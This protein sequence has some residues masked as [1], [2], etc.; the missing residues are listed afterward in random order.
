[1]GKAFIYTLDTS[2]EADVS[3][4]ELYEMLNKNP[5][6]PFERF[7]DEIESI[8]DRVHRVKINASFED[9]SK[10]IIVL[11][12][13]AFCELGNVNVKIIHAKSLDD[14]LKEFYWAREM[15]KLRQY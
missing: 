3:F 9:E 7:R 13:T 12:Y 10:K 4:K 5:I 14:G 11:D 15:G 8:L 1:M 2:I 6:E